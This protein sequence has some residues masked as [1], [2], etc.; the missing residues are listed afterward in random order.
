MEIQWT[1]VFFTLLA[2]MGCG[3]FGAIAVVGLGN[4]SFVS[5]KGVLLALI[6]LAVGGLSSVFHLAHPFNALYVL[7][8]LNTEFGKELL[9]MAAVGILMI[10]YL[11]RADKASAGGKRTLCTLSVI[12]AA[13]MAF[14]AGVTYVLVARSSWNTFLLPLS[15]LA[16]A[17]ALGC[18]AFGLIVRNASAQVL[19]RMRLASFIAIIAQGI[20]YLAYVSVSFTSTEA[21]T[22]FFASSNGFGFFWIGVL[23]FGIVL[24]FVLLLPY[25]TI[26]SWKSALPLAF[27]CVIIGGIAF[28]SMMYLL[29]TDLPLV[30]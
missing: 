11:L 24:P 26:N 6:M 19:A 17:C 23:L 5:K 15:Y 10:I 16:S 28:R 8:K 7:T 12:A 20:L 14:Q 25:R 9:L 13:W 29:G 4:P 2:C 30:L 18:I 21:D 27:I 22:S 1:L 3:L